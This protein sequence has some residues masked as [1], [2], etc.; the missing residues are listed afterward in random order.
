MK[1]I[2]RHLV[3]LIRALFKYYPDLKEQILQEL[4]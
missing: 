3:G 2:A 1:E 4:K